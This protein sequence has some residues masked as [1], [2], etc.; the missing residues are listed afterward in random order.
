[1]VTSTF[2]NFPFNLRKV[3]VISNYHAGAHKAQKI[4]QELTAYLQHQE[5]A[6]EL[7]D[8]KATRN[9]ALTVAT[10][11][12]ASFSEIVVIG[13]DGALNEAVNGLHRDIP[14][15]IIPAGSDDDFVKMLDI[16]KR[17]HDHI[18]SAIHGD[19]HRID[20]GLCN[21]RK[22]INGVGI[23]FDGQIVEDML[24][25]R[26]PL[27]TGHAAYY[28]HVVRILWGFKAK[29]FDY[30]VDDKEESQ[31]LILMTIGN[32]STFGGGFRLVPDAQ[33]QNGKLGVCTIGD[34]SSIGRFLKIPSLSSGA[35]GTFRQVNFFETDALYLEEN[36]ALFAHIDGERLG[37]PPFDIKVLPATLTIRAKTLA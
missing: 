13:G 24:R 16:G 22:F 8:T 36:S 35:H 15:G 28:Y 21:D 34:I 11:L 10:H 26:V 25:K 31:L 7:F 19:K 1:M 9:A 17:T 6:Y 29:T 14:M 27:L 33:L 2:Q 4:V 20:L 18:V 3:F 37:N 30:R 12:D 32:G 23:G 5:I